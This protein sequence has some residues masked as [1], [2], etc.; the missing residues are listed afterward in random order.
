M[1]IAGYYTSAGSNTSLFPESQMPSSLNDGMRQVQADIAAFARGDLWMQYGSG[2]GPGTIAWVSPTSFRVSGADVTAA[3]H[4]GRKVK[5][6]GASTGTVYA[7]IKSSSF[8]T[9][10]TVVLMHN[11]GSLVNETLTVWM[12]M[13]PAVGSPAPYAYA[14]ATY[15][16]RAALS[17]VTG[18]GERFRDIVYGY[19]AGGSVLEYGRVSYGVSDDTAGGEDSYI[20]WNTYVAGSLTN[21]MLAGQGILIGTPTG[22]FLGTGTLNLA[23]DV[24]INGTKVTG[25]ASTTQAG[26]TEFATGAETRTGVDQSR[27]ITPFGFASGTVLDA[28]Q[29]EIVLPGGLT[30]KYGTAAIAANP[31]TVTFTS[32]FWS[33]CVS[34]VVTAISTTGVYRAAMVTS[35]STTGFTVEKFSD[36]G[37]ASSVAFNWF[38]VGY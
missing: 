9:D 37:A 30:L 17:D 21:Q 22:G 24:Y 8:S 27:A 6:T 36:A 38:A 33:A 4:A 12:G 3:Y 15:A 19:N 20:G 29:G 23:S 10:T 25:A 31:T 5:V 13:E 28:T 1:T 32:A 35:Q 18:A 11:T 26:I 34:V 2:A 16:Q 7:V 14:A